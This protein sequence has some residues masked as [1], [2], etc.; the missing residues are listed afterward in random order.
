[1]KK[2]FSLLLSFF[3]V[4]I[5]LQSSAKIWQ[6]GPTRTYSKPSAVA[7]LVQH[8]DTVEID[9]GLYLGDCASWTKNNLLLRGASAF[10]HLEANGKSAGGKAIWVISGNNIKVE[11]IEFSG[12]AV[13]DSNGAGIRIEGNGLYIYH[14]YFHDN[15]NGMLGGSKGSVVVES[16]EFAYNGHGDGYSH[17]IYINHA[18]SFTLKFCY[19]HHAKI[20]HEVKSR[21]NRNYILY[22]RIMNEATG[23]ASRNI[24]LPNGGLAI[25]MGNNIQQGV[26]TQNSNMLGYGLEGLINTV[27]H[28]LYIIN[29]TFVN[30][31]GKS[32]IFISTNSSTALLKAYNNLFAGQPST[33]LSGSATTIDSLG[34]LIIADPTKAGFANLANY[35]Y[36]LTSASPCINKGVNSGS[37]GDFLLSPIYQYLHPMSSV[38]RFID[39]T[40]D[41]GASEFKNPTTINKDIRI[42]GSVKFY[43]S[44]SDSKM[45]IVSD[46]NLSSASALVYD[47]SGKL[48]GHPI[49]LTGNS[50][51]WNYARLPKGIYIIKIG[52]TECT[53]VKKTIL[54]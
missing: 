53:L 27:P 16:S 50:L 40:L 34:N 17:N 2:S 42:N 49:R 24:D 20:G 45:I 13:A 31:R 33:L 21:A 10:A 46:H 38:V 36:N 3:V 48:V 5:T 14:C 12:C 37:A 39:N 8:G 19:M 11:N 18:D 52:L 23:T 44:P 35:D 29:N 4:L 22:N 6:V 9:T 32:G 51:E 47:V 25:I 28:Q 7:A 1:M 26:N 54:R 41:V 30:Q 43:D 15:E